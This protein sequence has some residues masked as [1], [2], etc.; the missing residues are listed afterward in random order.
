M[1]TPALQAGGDSGF[2]EISWNGLGHGGLHGHQGTG[3]GRIAMHLHIYRDESRSGH[4]D[5]I[6]DGKRPRSF[7]L[8]LAITSGMLLIGFA[9]AVMVP[10]VSTMPGLT[11][12]VH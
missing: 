5:V 3:A 4:F 1:E 8:V 11:A 7:D 10:F 12:W 6:S 2:F 9:C